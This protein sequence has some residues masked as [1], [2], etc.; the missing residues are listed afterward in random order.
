MQH[1]I[2]CEGVG[3]ASPMMQCDASRN[4]RRCRHLKSHRSL[5][6]TNHRRPRFSRRCAPQHR[7]RPS[8]E[9][10][11]TRSRKPRAWRADC[12]RSTHRCGSETTRAR[13]LRCHQAHR[14]TASFFQH[15][16]KK[17]VATQNRVVQSAEMIEKKT[18]RCPQRRG[19]APTRCRD[20]QCSSRA[21]HRPARGTSTVRRTTSFRRHSPRRWAGRAG[22]SRAAAKRV[23][24]LRLWWWVLSCC[25]RPSRII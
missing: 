9:S 14:L 20:A 17:M 18:G 8:G 10:P 2:K 5:S 19:Q 15:I 24:P 1:L 3:L 11:L 12:L 22:G 25:A 4:R 21:S 16:E 6:W 23:V 7:S 13:P